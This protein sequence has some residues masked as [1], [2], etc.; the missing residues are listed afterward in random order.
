MF[1]GRNAGWTSASKELARS[2]TGG[3]ET[4][5]GRTGVNGEEPVAS[6]FSKEIA[7]G[8][9]EDELAGGRVGTDF[10]EAHAMRLR[11]DPCF[12]VEIFAP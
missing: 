9:V 10:D 8:R 2:R 3:S 6:D 12:I 5:R 11:L 4:P 1:D 7:R